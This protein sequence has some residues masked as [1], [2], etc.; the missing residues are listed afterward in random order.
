[1][2]YF[3][4]NLLPAA[5]CKDGNLV[6]RAFSSTIFKMADRREKTLGKAGITRRRGEGPGDEV[7]KDGAW[8]G[9]SQYSISHVAFFISHFYLACRIFISHFYLTSRIFISHVAF[10]SRIFISHL[11]F[12]SRIS[13]FYLAF[14][15]HISHFYLASRI[16]ILHLAFFISHLAFFLSHISYFYLA[17]RIFISHL[18]LTSRIFI[19]HLAFLSC[20]SHFLS[21]ISHFY[22]AFN[23][24]IFFSSFIKSHLECPLQASVGMLPY[25]HSSRAL[26]IFT[27]YTVLSHGSIMLPPRQPRVFARLARWQQ[28]LSA[29][30]AS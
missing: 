16:F 26:E 30:L 22:L 3:W 28:H 27:A 29:R 10:L 7:G 25:K 24:R 12:L 18:Y 17:S 23:S 13:H 21:R 2:A 1:M 8:P 5:V 15:S 14:I 4:E 9:I 6:P 19:S 11:V 20:I